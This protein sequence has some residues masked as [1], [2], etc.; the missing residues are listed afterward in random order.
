MFFCIS[1]AIFPVIAIG[2]HTFLKSRG[3]KHIRVSPYYARSNGKL[4]RFH[5]YLKKNFRAA[6]SEGKSWQEELPKILM[7]YRASPHPV[8]GKSPSMLLFNREI[9]MK[10]PHIE[11]NSNAELD[12]EHPSKCNLYQASMKDYHDAK[13]H[14]APHNF[15][16]GDIVYCANMKP[17]N[18]LDSKFLSAKHV[19]IETQARDTFSLVNVA[20]GATLVRNAKYLKHVPTSVYVDDC[21]GQGN[22]ETKESKDSSES[23]V[24]DSDACDNIEPSGHVDEQA[25]QNEGVVTTRSGR[26][27]KSTKDCDNFIYF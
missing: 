27:V 1:E 23:G 20:T 22:S 21:S 8:S 9:R 18:K 10:V 11:S 26:V 14:A 7:L 4:E 16:I 19:I 17:N 5:R 12:R 25:D 15:N 6:I 2:H 24:T 3:I 13:Q